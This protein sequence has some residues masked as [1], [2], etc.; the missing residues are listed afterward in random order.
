MDRQLQQLL[1]EAKDI[2]YSNW[3][4]ALVVNAL[5]YTRGGEQADLWVDMMEEYRRVFRQVQKR[6]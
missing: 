2:A 4:S 6:G 3:L 1:L 5:N